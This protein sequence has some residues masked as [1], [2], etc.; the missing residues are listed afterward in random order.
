[1]A[2]GYGYTALARWRQQISLA[3][4]WTHMRRKFYVLADSSPVATDV[5]RRIALLYGVEDEVRGSPAEQRCAAR[6][7]RSR[8]II[9]ELH[10]YLATRGHGSAPR[11]NSARRSVTHPLGWTVPFHRRRPYRPRFQHR[12][13]QQ[14]PARPGSNSRTGRS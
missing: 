12:P 10:H 5:W 1:M 3:F 4:C 11:A 6:A 2:D 14:Q 13:T 8:V 7:A 9:D